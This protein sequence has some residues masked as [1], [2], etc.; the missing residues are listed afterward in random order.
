[1]NHQ[2][3]SSHNRRS[4]DN[5]VIQLVRADLSRRGGLA[6]NRFFF[7]AT[8]FLLSLLFLAGFVRI[9]AL[10]WVRSEISSSTGELA[11]VSGFDARTTG[12][13]T[14]PVSL[15]SSALVAGTVLRILFA[16]LLPW[17]RGPHF[18][19]SV[20]LVLAATGFF[21]VAPGIIT[22]FRGLDEGGL[23][24]KMSEIDPAEVDWFTPGNVPLLF[25]ADHLDGQRRFWNR[26]GHTPKDGAV[27]YP[28]TEEVRRSWEEAEQRK[29]AEQRRLERE[30][31]LRQQEQR[32]E[33]LAREH[34]EALAKLET[35][36]EE[37]VRSAGKFT[38]A[39]GHPV[40]M[41]QRGSSDAKPVVS[42]G[43]AAPGGSGKRTVPPGFLS[44]QPSAPSPLPPADFDF[45]VFPGRFLQL[46]LSRR[47][48]EI[49]ADGTVEISRPGSDDVIV[50]GSG[51]RRSFNQADTLLVSPVGTS[52][53][54]LRLRW[55]EGGRESPSVAYLPVAPV[56]EATT[57]SVSP[58]DLWPAALVS[59]PS[60]AP[61]PA[62]PR[63]PQCFPLYPGKVFH[64]SV[65]SDT[66]ECWSD[67]PVIVGAG[68]SGGGV[69]ELEAYQRIR[70]SGSPKIHAAPAARETRHFFVQPIAPSPARMQQMV[71][72]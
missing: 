29:S 60:I 61:V 16:F 45:E 53:V 48:A 12:W 66:V 38:N 9:G 69:R 35:T 18:F 34:K 30:A 70:I 68:S 22:D 71:G 41:E 21:A 4:D 40:G 62:S 36:R 72:Y 17:T 46:G 59:V 54:R 1:M 43:K 2:P 23:P 65:H 64:I 50:V 26:P 14:G 31:S 58:S 51:M 27:A 42:F 39:S 11:R 7:F 3:S 10:L 8:I 47:S 20:F 25:Y 67:G 33:K 49:W 44:P 6:L 24:A 19:R 37:L 28:V 32:N 52:S 15:I 13:L 63:P 55:L 57:P 5:P 56:K